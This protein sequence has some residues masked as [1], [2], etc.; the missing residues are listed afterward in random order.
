MEVQDIRDQEK[1]KIQLITDVDSAI[2]AVGQR[3]KDDSLEPG[4][5]AETV[6]AL[7]MLVIARATL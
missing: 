1:T 6:K 5:Y 3:I 4:H 2:R 7:A